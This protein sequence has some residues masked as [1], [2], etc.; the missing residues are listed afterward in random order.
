MGPLAL[1]VVALEIQWDGR[2]LDCGIPRLHV[3]V[4]SLLGNRQGDANTVRE[5][6]VVHRA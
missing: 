6:G 4:M 2:W 3:P 1:V 5:L